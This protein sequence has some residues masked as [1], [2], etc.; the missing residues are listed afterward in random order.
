MDGVGVEVGVVADRAGGGVVGVCGGG[1]DGPGVGV[2][3][4]VV[5]VGAEGVEEGVALCGVLDATVCGAAAEGVGGDVG[6]GA[7]LVLLVLHILG[8]CC[9]AAEGMV[10]V[11]LLHD[12]LL[13]DL[14]HLL[15][16]GLE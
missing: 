13:H 3:K 5:A 10:C 11:G 16:H 12:H 7:G 9:A 15:C 8:G 4:E 14:L 1:G 2:T 6:A